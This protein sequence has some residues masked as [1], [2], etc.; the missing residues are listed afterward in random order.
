MK[1]KIICIGI[2]SMFLILSVS[3]VYSKEIG[4]SKVRINDH[5]TLIVDKD[6]SGD[7]TMIQ[8]AIDNAKSGDTILVRPGTYKENISIDHKSNLKIKG[9]NKVNTKIKSDH[10]RIVR[11]KNGCKYIE[12]SGFTILPDDCLKTG[13]FVRESS[14]ISICNNDVSNNGRGIVLS[15]S[16]NNEIMNNIVSNNYFGGIDIYNS[17]L[18]TIVKNVIHK[19][20][21]KPNA[22]GLG[23]SD[24]E[25]NVIHHNDFI[26][27][28][29]YLN[30][31]N[32]RA[33]YGGE[34]FWDDGSEGNYWSDYLINPGYINE[35]KYYI[36]SYRNYESN[37]DQSNNLDNFPLK[38]PCSYEAK[39]KI[40]TNMLLL[41][42]F[43]NHQ[44][45]LSLLNRFIL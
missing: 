37:F 38:K 1:R 28:G 40:H 13:I 35:G 42:F 18:N 9:E 10:D 43:E 44:N 14:Y 15:I 16:N 21:I 27:N 31:A 8:D 24:S 22:Q 17:S 3:V 7:Y 32:A 34:N 23:I 4:V 19:N 11:I 2:I 20:G 29:I 5:N 26:R 36:D 41:R 25:E 30:N 45:L 6:G 12:L 39:S 33:T